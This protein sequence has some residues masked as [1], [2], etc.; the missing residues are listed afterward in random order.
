MKSKGEHPWRKNLFMWGKGK[1]KTHGP[2]KVT[3]PAEGSPAA[4]NGHHPPLV[5]PEPPEPSPSPPESIL[6]FPS[7]VLDDDGSW[8]GNFSPGRFSSFRG[9]AF[10]TATRLFPQGLFPHHFRPR[11]KILEADPSWKQVV[12]CVVPWHAPTRRVWS[13][14]RGRSEGR[15]HGRVSCLP[16][17][18]VNT[19]D[20]W[21][22]C[23][24][25]WPEGEVY[26]VVPNPDLLEV[27]YRAA[28]RELGE[29]VSNW[30][31]NW[32]SHHSDIR[33]ILAGIVNEE[34]DAIGR[35]HFGFVYR[36][37]VARAETFAGVF[38]KLAGEEAGWQDVEEF[39]D[40]PTVESWS[41]HVARHLAE[42]SP[43]R[44]AF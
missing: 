36:L 28:I 14:V 1:M 2:R 22:P 20:A 32:R 8:Q 13:F 16:G 26:P 27:T 33:L 30:Q 44:A 19:I 39:L 37:D 5:E 7:D 9:D 43:T 15:L 23:P 25:D 10:E 29:E 40:L 42:T 38:C 11:T 17:G 18:H 31:E 12:A 34:S 4:T 41:R 24:P 21:P 35:C 3:L 6:C